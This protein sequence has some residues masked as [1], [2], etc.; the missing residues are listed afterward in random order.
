LIIDNG[1]L[2]IKDE[3][4]NELEKIK[5]NSKFKIQNLKLIVSIH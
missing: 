2:I 5:N 3:L 1:K 4:I